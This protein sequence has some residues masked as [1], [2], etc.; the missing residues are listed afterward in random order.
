[1]ARV[2]GS[3]SSG[4]KDQ[5]RTLLTIGAVI[6]ALYFGKEIFVPI[7]LAILLSFALAP[8]VRKLHTLGLGRIFPVLLTTLL[9]FTVIF[10][11]AGLV[12]SQLREVA[13][14]LPRY[15]ATMT[16]KVAAL[17]DATSGGVLQRLEGIFNRLDRAINKSAP[18]AAAPSGGDQAPSPRQETTDGNQPPMQVEIH[19]RPPTP[20][21]TVGT[22]AGTVLHPLATAGIVVIFVI[23]ILLQREDLRNRLIRLFGSSDLQRTTAAINDGAKRLSRY[24]LTQLLINTIAGA[25]IGTAAFAVGVPNPILWGILFGLMRFVPYIGPIIGGALPV[26]F[27][28]AVDQGWTMA[29]WMAGIIV[30]AELLIGQVVEPFLYGHN[31]GLSPVAVVVSATF[32]TA[33]WGPI[34]LLLAVPITVC[35]VVVGRHVEQLEFLDV[36]LGD[37]PPL[38]APEVFY[39]RMLAR[40]PVEVAEQASVCLKTM[41]LTEYFDRVLLPG[42]LL[43]QADASAER[44]SVERQLQIRDATEDVIEDL[45]EETEEPHASRWHLFG[46]GKA[47]DGQKNSLEE[48]AIPA[49]WQQ[50]GAILCIGARGPLDD[51]AS[52]MLGQVLTRRGLGARSESYAS[53]SKSAIGNLD[54]S[55]ARLIC[56]SC[57]DGTSSAYMR[58]ALRRIRRRAPRARIL[59]GAWW[60]QAE[61]NKPVL[62]AIDENTTPSEPQAT[63]IVDAVRFCLASASALTEDE[64]KIN[65]PAEA[66]NPAA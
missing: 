22:Y 11:L 19:Q 52:L 30:V 34:G 4:E 56:M 33:L 58:F 9:A 64:L 14:E 18:Q 38:T 61:D 28:A 66:E 37:R 36:L 62:Q 15:E 51:C 29:I 3:I 24:L 53:L 48:V 63:T 45:V 21:E 6:A 50:D 1:M 23:F 5:S 54:V 2:T 59:V 17:K 35:V 60:L 49:A 42:L 32:W 65:E 44:L 46:H 43:A 27:A 47:D 25:V 8:A 57:L 26:V 41:S 12:A 16:K 7:A 31:T 40:D 13:G 10:S 55:K 20:L 39:Q